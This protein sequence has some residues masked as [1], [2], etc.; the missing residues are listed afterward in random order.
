MMNKPNQGGV[1]EVTVVIPLYR[2]AGSIGRVVDE[3]EEVARAIDLELVLVND[4]SPDNTLEVCR[5]IATRCRV[6]LTLVDL[7]RNFGEHNAV[8]AGY[9]H[10]RGRWIV[11]LDDDGQ[12]PPSEI[13]RLLE[14]AKAGGHDVVFGR[15]RTKQHALWRNL[16]SW[17][18][19]KVA[20][21]TLDKPRGLYLSSFRC[22]SAFVACEV[23]RYSGPYPYIDGLILQ[24]TNK[25]GSVDV[26][27]RVRDTGA[28]G[29]T[30]RKL[31]HLWINMFVNFSVQP[32]RLATWLGLLMGAAGACGVVWVAALW[33]RGEGPSFGWGSLMAALL[34]FSGT[35]MLML[36]LIG[37]YLGR[38]YL[39]TNRRPQSIEREVL[40]ADPKPGP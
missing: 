8:M 5:E 26:G 6:P 37:E 9:R 27:H 11:N 18:A 12:N 31:V 25:L 20:E 38:T 23:M 7:S 1:P 21:W 13:P 30:M 40:R 15:Y 10:A 32:L 36:G 3:I 2:S 29:Y 33:W 17:F 34:L 24:T 35:Q 39:S 16:G 14:A 19:N 4:G 22:V 28:S